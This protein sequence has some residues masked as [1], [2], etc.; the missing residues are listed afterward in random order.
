MD[1][2]IWKDI[3]GYDHPYKVSSFGRVMGKSG[4]VRAVLLDRDGYQR[5]MLKLNGTKKWRYVHRLV[6]ISFLS[7]PENKGTVNHKD[8]IRNNNNI[9]NLEWA[10]QKENCL[11]GYRANGRKPTIGID[12]PHSKLTED[13]VREIKL[14]LQRGLKPTPL[15]RKYK[16]CS[17][18]IFKIKNGLMWKHIK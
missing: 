11:H 5:T 6:A 7:N 10:T 18:T 15:S 17:S 3:E 9:S 1:Q 4:R 14:S 12:S 13:Q 8:G 16:V 2:E